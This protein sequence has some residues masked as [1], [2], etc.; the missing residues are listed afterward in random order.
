MNEFEIDQIALQC[1]IDDPASVMLPES[2]DSRDIADQVRHRI[3]KIE[4]DCTP[5]W[6]IRGIQ[7][8]DNSQKRNWYFRDLQSRK[9]AQERYA[10]ID[11]LR[12]ED[13]VSHANEDL[14]DTQS[15]VVGLGLYG[16]YFYRRNALLPE[17]LDVLVIT[18]GTPNVAIDALRYRSSDLRRI[19]VNQT[20]P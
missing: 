7:Q 5:N 12:L 9:T 11:L 19:Y 14:V 16:S 13:I 3:V 15:R 20:K 18:E 8:A 2:V 6:G 4:F 1:L 17:D 10:N